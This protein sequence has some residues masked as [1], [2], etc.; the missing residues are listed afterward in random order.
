MEFRYQHDDTHHAVRIIQKDGQYEVLIG[1]RRYAVS[2]REVDA[3]TLDL[4][5]DGRYARAKHAGGTNDRWVAIGDGPPVNATRL[6][7][8]RRQRARGE[9][10]GSLAAT[11]PGLVTTVLVSAGDTVEAG[12]PLVIMEAMKME[13]RIAAPADGTVSAV[14]VAPGEQVE[15]GQALVEMG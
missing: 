13:L 6:M 5:I 1:E 9:G 2:A 10:G 4:L 15:R 14:H 8:R 11:M 7:H 12:Q 3:H